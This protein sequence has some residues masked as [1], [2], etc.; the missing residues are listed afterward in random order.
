VGP[1][2][3]NDFEETAAF[4]RLVLHIG[5]TSWLKPAIRLGDAVI[6][7]DVVQSVS[8]FWQRYRNGSGYS[9]ILADQLFRF[10]QPQHLYQNK[11]ASA[12]LWKVADASSPAVL[13]QTVMR[14]LVNDVSRGDSVQAF[15]RLWTL[16]GELYA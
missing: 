1:E 14:S 4:A 11:E 2:Q 9:I 3:T 6:T 13:R 8:Q 10:M 15:S 7:S 5:A 12:L 16:T